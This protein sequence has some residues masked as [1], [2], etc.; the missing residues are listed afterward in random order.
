MLVL[1]FV[2]FSCTNSKSNKNKN[3]ET[4]QL[5]I[6]NDSKKNKMKLEINMIVA[7]AKEAATYYEKVLNAEIISQTNHEAGMNETM[8]NLAG[9]EIRDL[10][11]NKE[12]GLYA[13]TEGAVPSMGINLFVDNID[14]FF[15]NAIN[16]GCRILS[17][18]QDFP[19][20]KAKNAVFSDK[21]NH[22]WVVNQQY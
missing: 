17:P 9:V 2:A 1:S 22:I 21:F 18:V 5:R 10:D 14:V 4:E 3:S 7:D 15:N 11:E 20:N 19:E 12:I 16:E 8:I 13:P 6:E